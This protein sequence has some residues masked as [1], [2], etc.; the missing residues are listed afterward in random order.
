M[1]GV[2]LSGML[3][4]GTAGLL[5]IKRCGGIALVQDPAEAE[6]ASMPASA[7][8]HV[9]VDGCLPLVALG[10]RLA[11][12]AGE[13]DVVPRSVAPEAVGD[14]AHMAFGQHNDPTDLD[15]LGRPSSFT[16]PDCHG[17]LWELDE[18][19]VLR[20]RCHIGHA[21]SAES[22]HAGQ[23]EHQ[24]QALSAALRALE[25]Q[26][27]LFMRMARRAKE[28]GNALGFE[29]YERRARTHR[30]DAETLRRMLLRSDPPSPSAPEPGIVA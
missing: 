11:E 22:L 2:V 24:E 4:D 7:L 19:A 14:E 1:I 20:Y 25:E 17:T 26:A 10:K 12:L 18:G 8:A 5:A 21:Y 28:Q 13:P 27:T 9:A 3:D 6:F 23:A 16:C 29:Q 30:H 15:R